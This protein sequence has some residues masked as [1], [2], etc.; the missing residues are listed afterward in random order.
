MDPDCSDFTRHECNL[1]GNRFLIP[2]RGLR[3]ITG[4]PEGILVDL[5]NLDIGCGVQY[6][7][8]FLGE[9]SGSLLVIVRVSIF[10]KMQH[11]IELTDKLY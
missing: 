2:N 5:L 6:Q 4:M 9:K 8:I 10:F 11:F 7:G 1:T 3:K